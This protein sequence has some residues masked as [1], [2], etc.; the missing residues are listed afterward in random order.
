MRCLMHNGSCEVTWRY[1]LIAY[2]A[3]VELACSSCSVEVSAVAREQAD[4]DSRK[5][6]TKPLVATRIVQPNQRKSLL[7]TLKNGCRVALDRADPYA[8]DG[9]AG[10]EP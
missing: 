6:T 4:P 9:T 7:N 2:I 8:V 1:G 5:V 3:G 10:G